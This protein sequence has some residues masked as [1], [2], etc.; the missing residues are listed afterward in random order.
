[1]T[2]PS[3]DP[4]ATDVSPATALETANPFG[5]APSSDGDGD[6]DTFEMPP[7]PVGVLPGIVKTC[8][9]ATTEKDGRSKKSYVLEIQ[10]TD[11]AFT[12]SSTLS[13]WVEVPRF[14]G[15]MAQIAT[16]FGL[17]TRVRG[18]VIDLPKAV[19]YNNMPGYFVFSTYT[20]SA[21]LAQ[22]TLAWGLPKPGASAQFD[23]W[24]AS[25]GL[26]E[27]QINEVK[28]SPGVLP[29]GFL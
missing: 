25:S 22:P 20:D 13:M 7:T 6:F 27:A 8:K 23:E 5:E 26:T 15:R 9:L 1:M 4:F 29:I 28:K 2:T 16:A 14:N 21:G 17:P 11:P 3:T 10:C 19:K 24:L 18:N 12:G